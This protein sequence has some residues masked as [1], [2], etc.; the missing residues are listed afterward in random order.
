MIVEK[1]YK[2][3]QKV[4]TFLSFKILILFARFLLIL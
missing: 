3:F 1:L 4:F 2:I